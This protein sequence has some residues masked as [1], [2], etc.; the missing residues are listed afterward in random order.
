MGIKFHDVLVRDTVEQVIPGGWD[1]S[2]V[3]KQRRR[4]VHCEATQEISHHS[5]DEV[6]SVS[7]GNAMQEP[8]VSE[9]L[10]GARAG[11][12][13]ASCVAVP[14]GLVEETAA[15]ELIINKPAESGSA[16]FPTAMPGF[17]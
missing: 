10:G 6:F 14:G 16:F 2:F 5:T 17:S 8:R 1:H 9:S 11:R 4:F 3:R 7:S 12:T 13:K 15:A